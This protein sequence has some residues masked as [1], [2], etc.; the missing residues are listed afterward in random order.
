MAIDRSAVPEE[1][2]W[3]LNSLFASDEEYRAEYA[4]VEEKLAA[5]A[6]RLRAV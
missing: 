5:I 2:T 3:N 6:V 1:L 4:V